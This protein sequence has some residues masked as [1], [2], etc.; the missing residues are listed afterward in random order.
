MSSHP[1]LENLIASARRHAA[2]PMAVVYPCDRDALLAAAE[3][4]KAQLIVPLLVGPRDRILAAAEAAH[5][6]VSAFELHDIGGEPAAAA[7]AAVALCHDGRARAMMKGSLHTD[8][9]MGA[10]VASE[11]GLRGA[12]RISHVFVID[13][14]GHPRPLLIADAV[15][16]I[17]PNL[18]AKRDIVQ[19]AVDFARAIGIARPRVAILSAVETV[20]PAI[21]GSADAPALI[22]MAREGV[23]S[24]A[25]VDGPFA[26]DN[27]ISAEAARIKGVRS[28]VAGQPDIL[29]VPGLEAGN[30][31]YKALVYLAR[32][33]CA[34]LVLGAKVPIVLTSRADS[35]QSRVAS[36]ALAVLMGSAQHADH[37]QQ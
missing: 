32:G 27:A 23:I 10:A 4:A 7:R 20:N 35:I 15:V 22:E 11:G 3:A 21:A 6:D 12:R 34:G 9:L 24:G 33:E 1:H 36:C 2:L 31:L 8:E 13:V 37:Q 19:N 25:I 30:I 17:T 16:N 5:V 14:P 29:L 26:M 28:D 18:A